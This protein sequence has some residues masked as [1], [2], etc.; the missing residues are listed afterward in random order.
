[1]ASQDPGH[2]GACQIGAGVSIVGTIAGDAGVVVAGRIEGSI[3]LGGPLTVEAGARVEAQVRAT[4]V[5][6]RGTV[7]GSVE[8]T[9]ALVIEAGASLTGDV[10]TPRLSIAEGAAFRGSVDMSGAAS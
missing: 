8:A 10:R 9:E 2:S 5:T 1:M 4:R 3:A 7:V 6:V